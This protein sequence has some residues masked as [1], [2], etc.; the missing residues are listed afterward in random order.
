MPPSHLVANF[1]GF[2]HLWCVTAITLHKTHR[3]RDLLNKQKDS[4]CKPQQANVPYAVSQDARERVFGAPAPW[5][6][7]RKHIVEA[8][9]KKP[10]IRLSRS[11]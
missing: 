7:F 10:E 2:V 4:A 9:G 3:H 11:F 1:H 8:P 5:N 6:R